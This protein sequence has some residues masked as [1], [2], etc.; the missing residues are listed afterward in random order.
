MCIE[1]NEWMN[2]QLIFGFSNAA[3]I[4]FIFELC[5]FELFDFWIILLLYFTISHLLHNTHFIKPYRSLVLIILLLDFTISHLLDFRTFG[6]LYFLFWVSFS[7]SALNSAVKL[8]VLHVELETVKHGVL[9][10]ALEEDSVTQ[11]FFIGSGSKS[12]PIHMWKIRS[13]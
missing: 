8:V 5:I 7:G 4:F 12:W 10:D 2:I 13:L 6:F 3:Y 11:S 1:I 9:R